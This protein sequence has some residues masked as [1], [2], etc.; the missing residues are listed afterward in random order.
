MERCDRQQDLRLSWT[1]A[2]KFY[3]VAMAFDGVDQTG[4]V[5]SFPNSTSSNTKRG[6]SNGHKCDGNKVIACESSGLPQGTS[7]GTLNLR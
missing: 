2:T 4:G 1:G 3:L 5:T 6:D 7:T